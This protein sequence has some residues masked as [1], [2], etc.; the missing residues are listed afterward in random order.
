[1]QITLKPFKST[2]FQLVLFKLKLYLVRIIVINIGQFIM[3]YI[4]IFTL[5]C[6]FF[7]YMNYINGKNIFFIYIKKKKQ[8]Q[9]WFKLISTR[10]NPTQRQR[11]SNRARK[12]NNVSRI[13][14]AAARQP[15]STGSPP[16]T[17]PPPPLAS[18]R[19]KKTSC[20]PPSPI[21][22]HS[23]SSLRSN[24]C[25]S[26]PGHPQVDRRLLDK[27]RRSYE[28]ITFYLSEAPK[29]EELDCAKPISSCESGAAL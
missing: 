7:I 21:P 17:S 3:I 19:R 6:V 18:R 11:S 20:F 16:A 14:R 2:K 4:F 28:P 13:D 29:F 23:P 8:I 15:K 10:T 5:L 9:T 24:G 12:R 1:M 25:Q 26:W 22:P 27:M